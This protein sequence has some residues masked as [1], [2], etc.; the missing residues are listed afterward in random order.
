MVMKSRSRGLCFNTTAFRV[1]RRRGARNAENAKLGRPKSKG[2]CTV[3]DMISFFTETYRCTATA[4]DVTLFEKRSYMPLLILGT[5]RAE[6]VV[7]GMRKEPRPPEPKEL[8]MRRVALTL[9]ALAIVTLTAG[10]AEAGPPTR[11]QFAAL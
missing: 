2:F 5:R 8:P 10:K 3:V 9:A 6:D 4:I 7:R 1:Q 11:V